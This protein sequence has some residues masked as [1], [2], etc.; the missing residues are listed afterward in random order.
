MS[1]FASWEYIE[2]IWYREVK[3][4]WQRI[5][6]EDGYH[7]FDGDVD[8]GKFDSLIDAQL[9]LELGVYTP[10]PIKIRQ[11]YKFE[12]RT[13]RRAKSWKRPTKK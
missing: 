2:G 5:D 10:E 1:L 7:A 8:L 9:A 6:T 11:P 13:I 12:L 3:G 4:V